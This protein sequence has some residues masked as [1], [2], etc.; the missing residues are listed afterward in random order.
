[1]NVNKARH[2][3]QK[4]GIRCSNLPGKI[5]IE[6]CV[7]YVFYGQNKGL[8]FF[9]GLEKH[10]QKEIIISIFTDLSINNRGITY[11]LVCEE[12]GSVV[13]FYTHK[14]EYF[15][16]NVIDNFILFIS[17]LIISFN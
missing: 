3:L 10:P 4:A 8:R 9:E 5:E 17:F 2:M 7:E 1:M 12:D 16:F 6:N 11:Y 15:L 14:K 13:N